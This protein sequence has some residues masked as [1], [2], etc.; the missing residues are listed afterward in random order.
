M[1]YMAHSILE[2]SINAAKRV[3]VKKVVLTGGEPTL[4]DSLDD[5]CKFIF[6]NMKEHITTIV[7]NG[8][9]LL[10]VL[11]RILPYIKGINLSV[12][13]FEKSIYTRYTDINPIPVLEEL[14]KIHSIQ[15][16]ANIV[17]TKDNAIEVPHIVKYCTSRG[18]S[19]QLM[20]PIQREH[21]C[22][23]FLK[24]I[25]NALSNEVIFETVQLR[26]TPALIS[27]INNDTYLTIKK[28][29]YSKLLR[30]S[31]CDGCT[32]WKECS[33]AVCGVRVDPKGRVYSCI[34]RLSEEPDLETEQA[35]ITTY[36]NL[37]GQMKT[38]NELFV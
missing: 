14:S 9:R 38:S 15:K 17:V 34:N 20:S 8:T 30:W 32:K 4:V 19:V 28:P 29:R 10:D 6:E 26:Y 25:A 27:R 7:T 24:D 35:I 3:G 11:D 12:S 5:I 13:S 22:S 1:S 21:R 2:G 36:R 16:K 37:I 31:I 23:Y 33:E 18:I